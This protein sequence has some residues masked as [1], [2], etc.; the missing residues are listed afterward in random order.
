M[1][2]GRIT[3]KCD[4]CGKEFTREKDCYNRSEANR[5]EAWAQTVPWTCT[6][7]Y[8]ADKIAKRAEQDAKLAPAR[9]AAVA[10]LPALK[11]SEKQI[12][13]ANKIRADVYIKLGTLRDEFEPEH[14]AAFDDFAQKLA[15]AHTNASEWIDAR[16]DFDHISPYFLEAGNNGFVSKEYVEYFT[17]YAQERGLM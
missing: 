2:K 11:G 16:F 12:A 14:Q 4:K 8:H 3:C 10:D 6:D 7:C 9:A 17:A 5:W 13:W 1:A 15:E